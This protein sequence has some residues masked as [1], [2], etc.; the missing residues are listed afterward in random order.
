[1]NWPGAHC[2]F[3][4]KLTWI[5]FLGLRDTIQDYLVQSTEKP[6]ENQFSNDMEDDDPNNPDFDLDLT[7]IDDDEIDGY[8]MSDKEIEF[9]TKMWM[10][11]NAEYLREQV[12]KT[13]LKEV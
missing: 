13:C 3:F 10:R 1:M 6:L 8:I 5:F 9:K 2:T 7:G 12:I 11:V 4:V